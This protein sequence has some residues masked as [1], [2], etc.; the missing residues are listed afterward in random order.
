MSKAFKAAHIPRNRYCWNESKMKAFHVIIPVNLSTH[1]KRHHQ[2]CFNGDWVA[3][4]S[5]HSKVHGVNMGTIW[6]RQ[7]PGG[8]H[9]DR[10]NFAVWVFMKALADTHFIIQNSLSPIGPCSICRENFLELDVHFGSLTIETIE[11]HPAYTET[12]FFS[13]YCLSLLI[14]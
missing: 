9:V 1:C 8:P 4:R 3:E 13:K 12:M 11:Q 10:V 5:N 2:R 14:G 6:G 7:D